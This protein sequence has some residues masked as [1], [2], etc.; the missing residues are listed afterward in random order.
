MC[1]KAA[2]RVLRTGNASFPP[3]CSA[4]KMNDYFFAERAQHMPSRCLV[5]VLILAHRLLRQFR[6]YSTE[7]HRRTIEPCIFGLA[8]SMT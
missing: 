3:V 5:I 4:I 7:R 8:D 6:Q 1:S 2:S